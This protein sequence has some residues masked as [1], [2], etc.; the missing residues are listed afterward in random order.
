MNHSGIFVLLELLL[1]QSVNSEVK[2]ITGYGHG[3]QVTSHFSGF[4]LT[5]TISLP[6]IQKTNVPYKPLYHFP[7]SLKGVKE[8]DFT[9]VFGYPGSTSEYV[10]SYHIDMV[11]NYLNPKMIEIRTKKIEIMEA[12]MNTDPLIRIQY[13]AKKSGIANS[14]KKWI[15]ENLGLEKMK[16]IEK[17]QE[18]E[19]NL[20]AWINADNA[21]NEQIRESSSGIQGIIYKIERV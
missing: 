15:G 19:K 7:I 3:I 2:L 1:Q 17:K 11:K 13:S 10:P 8:G 14:W 16:T 20:T 4:M 21:T 9:M 5:R 18:F 6:I 12:A